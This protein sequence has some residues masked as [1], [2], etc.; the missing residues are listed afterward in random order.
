MPK[1]P[2][3]LKTRKPMYPLQAFQVVGETRYGPQTVYILDA[4]GT[5]WNKIFNDPWI[6]LD[7]L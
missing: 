4:E 6:E 1:E 2:K 3:P 5:L 7:P